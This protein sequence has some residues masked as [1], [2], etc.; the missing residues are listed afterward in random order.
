MVA[1]IHDPM[2][3][4]LAKLASEEE[5]IEGHWPLATLPRLKEVD[6]SEDG[7]EPPT[8]VVFRAAAETR[9]VL[10]GEPQ[11]WLHLQVETSV[12]LV[13]QRCLT[14]MPV[15]LIVDRWIRFVADEKEAAALDEESEDDVL[16]LSRWLN[17]RELAE[18]ELLLALP[19]VPRHDACPGALPMIEVA[20]EVLE[21]EEDRPN[22][23]AVLE[24]LKGKKDPA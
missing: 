17:L 24:Q 7:S 15:P 3:L 12:R 21:Q 18:D 5:A 8:D 10:G 9:A 6:Q 16:A 23:F 22:P 4:D 2:R 20:D 13:C 1:S 11:V 19:L 14:V